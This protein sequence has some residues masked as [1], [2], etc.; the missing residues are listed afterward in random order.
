MGY[1]DRIIN[2]CFHGNNHE[3]LHVTVVFI[4]SLISVSENVIT[5]LNVE[6]CDEL[7]VAESS[8]LTRV[9]PDI[10]KGCNFAYVTMFIF[11]KHF[12]F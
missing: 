6:V 7:S 10:Y 11:S 8:V 12:I 4:S 9:R 2:H 5:I 3:F 1:I